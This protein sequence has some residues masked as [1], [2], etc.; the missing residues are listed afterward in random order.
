MKLFSNIKETVEEVIVGIDEAGRGPVI[1]PMVYAAYIMHANEY[2]ER[3]FIDSKQLTP[4]TRKNYYAT[5]TNFAYIIIEPIH[6][7]TYMNNNIKNLN[8]ISE[9]AVIQL[10]TEV[11][12]KCKNVKMVYVDALGNTTNYKKT[13]QNYFKFNFTIEPKADS[14]YEV[15]SAASIVAKINRDIFFTNKI[16]SNIHENYYTKLGYEELISINDFNHCGS[17]YPSD[18]YTQ[19]WLKN[20]LRPISGFNSIV[21]HSW[22]TIQSLLGKRK[23]KSIKA[24]P[25]FYFTNK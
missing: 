8:Q 3:R 16:N 2:C 5:M 24:I 1:G 9:E 11:N 19:Q 10:L 7:T 17:G 23:S 14:T 4:A 13:L 22:G 6:I 18:P 21:R 12:N 20:N 25:G 15:V